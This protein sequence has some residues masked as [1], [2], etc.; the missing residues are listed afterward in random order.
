VKYV[1]EAEVDAEIDA[2]INEALHAVRQK[3]E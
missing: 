3:A 2:T 1:P